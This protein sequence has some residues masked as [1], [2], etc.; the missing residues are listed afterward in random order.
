MATETKEPQGKILFK[1]T[2]IRTMKKDIKMLREF[3]TKKEQAKSLEPIA[4]TVTPVAPAPK[5]VK[6]I[7]ITA[8]QAPNPAQ[9]TEMEKQRAFALK[10]DKAQAEAKLKELEA[11]KEAAFAKEKEQLA[12][13]QGV[14]EKTLSA[15]AAK[16]AT[17]TNENQ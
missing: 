17:A 3:D 14:Q 4:P 16:E 6:K 1:R 5:P 7:E 2:D 15:V 11:Q 13:K 12:V 9:A 8:P 10:A